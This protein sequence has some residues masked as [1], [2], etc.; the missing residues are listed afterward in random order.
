MEDM[1]VQ[2]SVY[3]LNKIIDH[4]D[5]RYLNYLVKADKARDAGKLKKAD[6]YKG[7]ARELVSLMDAINQAMEEAEEQEG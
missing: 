6:E 4:L 7:I 2:I 5:D 3:T 1:K